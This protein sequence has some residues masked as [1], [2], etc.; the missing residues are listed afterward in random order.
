MSKIRRDFSARLYQLFD[1][2]GQPLPPDLAPLSRYAW[3]DGEL[4]LHAETSGYATN[5]VL[6]QAS[7]DNT[8]V[9][10]EARGDTY[11]SIDWLRKKYPHNADLYWRLCKLAEPFRYADGP[12]S[13]R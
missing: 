11:V 2:N 9:C 6:E 7:Q 4:F 1:A 5:T 10:V 3:I 8:T 13:K 12:E